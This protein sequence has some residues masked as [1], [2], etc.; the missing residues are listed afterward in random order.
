[1]YDTKNKPFIVSVGT[2]RYEKSFFKNKK[3]HC[4]A[5]AQIRVEDPAEGGGGHA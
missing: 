4:S 1:L 2:E 3:K 5:A